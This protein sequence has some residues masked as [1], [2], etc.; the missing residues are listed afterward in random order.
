MITA[1]DTNVLLDILLPNDDFYEASAKA[2]EAAACQGSI[3]ICDVVYAELCVHFQ[4][5]RQCDEFLDE[6]TI[7]PEPL[8]RTPS[9]SSGHTA[10]ALTQISPPR[11]GASTHIRGA[12]VLRVHV[13]PTF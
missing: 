9:Y 5:Q 1:I 6:T 4:T 10:S 2:L 13:F 7:R 3:V 12:R 11:S 8:S